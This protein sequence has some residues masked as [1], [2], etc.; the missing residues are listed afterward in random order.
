MVATDKALT[1][2]KEYLQV[3]QAELAATRLCPPNPFEEPH[4]TLRDS[5]HFCQWSDG[6]RRLKICGKAIRL[7]G[8]LW[9]TAEGAPRFLYGQDPGLRD[10]YVGASFG[11]HQQSLR[12]VP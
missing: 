11:S 12:L 3:F 1:L 10:L 6:V 7:E 5:D 8:M 9:E 4:G 2:S